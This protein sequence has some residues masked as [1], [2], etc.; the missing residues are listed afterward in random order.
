MEDLV[1]F[2]AIGNKKEIN[3]YD[4]YVSNIFQSL[5]D[6]GIITCYDIELLDEDVLAYLISIESILPELSFEV[7]CEFNTY[8]PQMQLDVSIAADG[9]IFKPDD[10]YFEH[11]KASIKDEIIRDW[12]SLVWLFDKDAEYLSADLYPRIYSTENRLRSVITSVMHRVYGCNWW[13][14]YVPAEIKQKYSAR[15]AGYKGIV[16]VFKNIDDKLMGIDVGDLYDIINYKSFA[17]NADSNSEIEELISKCSKGSEK[18]IVNLL[19]EHMI[20]KEDLWRDVFSQFFR[21]DFKEDFQK[22]EKNRNHV[23]HNKPL[24]RDAYSVIIKSIDRINNH[25]NQAMTSINRKLPSVEDQ[26]LSDKYEIEERERAEAIERYTKECDAGI[27][28]RDTQAINCLYEEELYKSYI[29]ISDALRFREDIKLSSFKYS[30]N[31]NNGI[32]FSA[33]SLV[34]SHEIIFKYDF[35]INDDEGAESVLDIYCENEGQS[36]LFCSITYINGAAEYDYEQ[37]SYM[38]TVSDEFGK[39]ELDGFIDD[40]ASFID[41]NLMNYVEYI[42]SIRYSYGKD[43]EALP[44]AYGVFCDKC[45]EEYICIDD[46]LAPF[47]VCLKCGAHHNVSQCERC[48]TYYENDS[49]DEVKLCTNCMDYYDRQ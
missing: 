44:I 48:G 26:I 16:H 29:D 12:T 22:F 14:K 10:S 23:A 28:I 13:E 21:E 5:V 27:S 6:K 4:N 38:P 31:D 15:R 32:L 46:N 25:L 2:T 35:C 33:K 20:V 39:A 37:T 30:M 42:E 17:W 24:D 49:D 1:K 40:A 36:E 11:I 7:I 3:D 45:C 41:E 43:G 9:Y 19:K 47:G 34:D 8:K 18:R